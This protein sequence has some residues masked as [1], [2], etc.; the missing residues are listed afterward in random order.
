MLPRRG[1]DSESSSP[2][3]QQTASDVE[4]P[5]APGPGAGFGLGLD[6]LACPGPGTAGSGRHKR[7]HWQVPLAGTTRSS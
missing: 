4:E 1:K 5:D 2:A 3:V 7:W 6:L